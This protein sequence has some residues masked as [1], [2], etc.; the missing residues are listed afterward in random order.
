M[1]EQ[2]FRIDAAEVLANEL[3]RRDVVDALAGDTTLLR[4][5][6]LPLGVVLG[7]RLTAPPDEPIPEVSEHEASLAPED[8]QLN[9]RMQK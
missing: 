5:H 3:I 1:I 9:A 7:R 6:V 4:A 2:P 8:R